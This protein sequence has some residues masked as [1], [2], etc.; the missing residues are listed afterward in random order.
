MSN[1]AL[2]A[3]QIKVRRITRSPSEALLTTDQLNFYINTFIQYD[4]PEQ[5]RLNNLRTTLTFFTTPYVDVYGNSSDPTDPLYNFTNIYTTVHPPIYVAGFQAFY[6]Q[7][8][9]YFYNI[10]PQINSISQLP[11]SGD[12]VNQT[13]SGVVNQSQSVNPPGSTQQTCLLRN[14]VLFSSIDTSGNGLAIIDYPVSAT[15]GAL[16]IPGVP[17]VLPSPYGQINYITG[18]FTV[19]FPTAPGLGQAV[20]SQTVVQQPSRP[21][22]MLFYDGQFTLRPVPDQPYRVEMEVYMRPSELLAQNQSPQLQEWWQ[23]IAYGASKKVFEDR[24]D[25]DSVQ[26]IMPEFKKQEA[27]CLRRTLVQNTNQRV[28]TIYTDQTGLGSGMSSWGW[29]GGPF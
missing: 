6:T 18:A 2:S 13:F 22:S 12:G 29:G 23:Y 16:G 7:S 25:L 4:F 1:S 14:N 26:L 20:N 5:I 27:L 11:Q 15:I 21:L 3:I 28:A 17:E 8:R 9:E 10:Y 19:N 24:M